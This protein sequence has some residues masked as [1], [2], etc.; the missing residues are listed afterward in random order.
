MRFLFIVLQLEEEEEEPE[1]KFDIAVSVKDPEKIGGTPENPGRNPAVAF[2][3]SQIPSFF[4]SRGRDE[5]LHGLQSNDTG[6]ELPVSAC[7]VTCP[8]QEASVG[9]WEGSRR[10]F[11][12]R[13][14][15]VSDLAAD[16]P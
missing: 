15:R 10:Q 13:L 16:V 9:N 8:S 6:E 4:P 1:D 5:R 14:F 12:L 3:H 7:H 2:S 11:E